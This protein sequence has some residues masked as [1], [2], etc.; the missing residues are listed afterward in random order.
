M[1]ARRLP[2]SHAEAVAAA[3]RARDLHLDLDHIR[4]EE[5]LDYGDDEGVVDIDFGN[6]GISIIKRDRELPLWGVMAGHPPSHGFSHTALTTS[7]LLGARHQPRLYSRTS[8]ASSKRS[9]N[10]SSRSSSKQALLEPHVAHGGALLPNLTG[11]S[12]FR[13]Y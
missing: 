12:P 8:T 5:E 9:S 10:S 6:A 1:P 13:L 2:R 4:A 11:N 3:S 7:H